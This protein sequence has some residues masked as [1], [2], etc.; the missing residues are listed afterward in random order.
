[1]RPFEGFVVST[2]GGNAADKRHLAELITRG[3]GVYSKDLTRGCSHL[4]VKPAAR[5]GAKLSDKE[6]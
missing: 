2:S 4:L 5:D 1:M 6:K 3:G